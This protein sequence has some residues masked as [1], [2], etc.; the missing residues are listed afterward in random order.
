M[1]DLFI[2]YFYDKQDPG[3]DYLLI[4]INWFKDKKNH[5]ILED[6]YNKKK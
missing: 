3:N 2:D 1:T 6:Y 5:L 4:R